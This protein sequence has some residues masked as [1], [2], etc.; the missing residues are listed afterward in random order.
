MAVYG[1]DFGT[2]YSCIAVAESDSDIVVVPSARNENTVPSVVMFRQDGRPVVGRAAKNAFSLPNPQ[3][4]VAYV[5]I[6][7]HQDQTDSEYEVA[8]GERRP[9]SPVEVASCIYYEM[10]T[11]SNTYRTGRQLVPASKAVITVPAACTDVQR[12][13]TKIAAQLAGIEV[14]KVI[15]E[16]TAAAISYNIAA[17]ETV[18]IFDL[19]GGTLD[20]SIIHANSQ[21][22]YEVWSCEGNTEL[23][24]KQWDMSLIG[25]CY[26]NLGLPFDPSKITSKQLVN[27]EQSKIDLCETGFADIAFVDSD[28]VQQMTSV[29]LEE[30]QQNS[31]HLVREALRVVDE[32]LKVARKDHPDMVLDRI[33]LA[34]G[35]SKMPAIRKSL[36]RHLPDIRVDLADPDQA[37][38][39]GAARYA[40]SLVAEGGN[41]DISIEEKGH[42]YGYMSINN[43]GRTVVHNVINRSDPTV[44]EQMTFSQYMPAEGDKL[45]V[46]II[47]SNVSKT[48]YIYNGQTQFFSDYVKFPGNVPLGAR[49]DFTLSRDADGLVHLS[50]TYNGEAQNFEFVTTVRKVSDEIIRRVTE[51]LQKMNRK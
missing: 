25:L 21:N 19:G 22:D 46:T 40:N 50:A 31:E 26:E 37:I 17:G 27:I 15:S 23:G 32:T 13:K 2:C 1:I 33:C 45:S 39:K 34:G 42:A 51:H 44:I 49:I 29:T 30:F 11:Q 3:N 20:V 8:R 14:L 36:S 4:V 6:Q 28:G 35:S 16:P 41:F 18:M 43:H 5:K 7:M 10:L 38:A 48:S 12:E 24:G 9:L 47:E